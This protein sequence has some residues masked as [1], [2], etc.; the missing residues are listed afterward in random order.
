M[1]NLHAIDAVDFALTAIGERNIVFTDEMTGLLS[2]IK[3]RV[4]G[5]ESLAEFDAFTELD[6]EM[7]K[8]NDPA[9]KVAAVKAGVADSV[10][11]T[12]KMTDFLLDLRNLLANG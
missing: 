8:I 5:G 6:I 9:L 2:V 1:P 12:S 11:P 10:V 7:V 3:A 4:D